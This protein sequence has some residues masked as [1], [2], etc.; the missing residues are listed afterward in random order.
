[1]RSS[2]APPH[3]AW[4]LRS[5]ASPAPCAPPAGSCCGPPE[6]RTPESPPGCPPPCAPACSP[7]RARSSQHRLILA[8]QLVLHLLDH[9][10]IARAGLPHVLLKRLQDHANFIVDAV[11]D[12]KSL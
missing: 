5:A 9:L 2:A 12:P 7:Y 8:R 4:S 6:N 10:R 11:L 1:M 3:P